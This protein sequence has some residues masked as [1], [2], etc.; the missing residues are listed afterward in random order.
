MR[1]A[2]ARF[3]ADELMSG[4]SEKMTRSERDAVPRQIPVALSTASVFPERT[5][6]AFELAARLGYDGIE[7]MV[8]ADPISQ[9]PAVLKRLSEYH[10][11]PVLAV[12]SPCLL[13]TQRVWGR[14]PWAKLARSAELAEKLGAKVVVVHPPFR[15]QR[16]YVRDFEH[17]I[18]KMEAKTGLTF[19]VENLYPLRAG[20]TE[21]AGFAPHWSP[22]ELDVANTTLDLSHTSVS[23]SDAVE[24]AKQLG[25]RLAHVHLADGSKPG[26]PDEHLVPGRGNQPCR[27]VLELLPGLGFSGAVVLE[28]STRR[29]Q[30]ARERYNDLAEALRFAKAYLPTAAVSR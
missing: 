17:G 22:V 5:A 8:T 11:I 29:A 13:I 23:E 30:N 1:Q 7:V 14:E 27:E 20:A 25:S 15:W 24:M 6:D 4:A 18:G 26:L 21:V 9:D 10:N 2:A 16:E 12:H 3:C 28:I 19:A